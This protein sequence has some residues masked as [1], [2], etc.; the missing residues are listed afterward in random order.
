MLAHHFTTRPTED[1][2]FFTGPGPQPRARGARHAGS[3]STE[4]G[5]ATERIHDG[6]TFCRLVIRSDTADVVTDLAMDTLPDFPASTT[7]AG[8]TLA[9]E[10]LAGRKLPLSAKLS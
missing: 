6:D 5:S 1:L 3:R 7:I 2:D 10:E 9:P 8:L 4:A